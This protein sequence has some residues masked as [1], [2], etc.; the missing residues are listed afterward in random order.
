MENNKCTIEMVLAEKDSL[1]ERLKAS[2]DEKEKIKY[3][4]ERKIHNITEE[5]NKKIETVIMNTKALVKALT[6]LM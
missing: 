3:E 6:E 1:V 5:Y 2:E 4:Y